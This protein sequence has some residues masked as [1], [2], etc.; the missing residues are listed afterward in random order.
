MKQLRQL[1]DIFLKLVVLSPLCVAAA[2]ADE[3]TPVE[4]YYRC[5]AHMTQSRP[6]YSDPI[7]ARIKAKE[8]DPIDACL[9]IF[10]K[11]LF[12]QAGG[13][14]IAN[15][16]DDTAQKVVATF[17]RLHGS[18]V[19][20]K[21]LG[22]SGNAVESAGLRSYYN[23]DDSSLYFTRAMFN[24]SVPVSSIV[25][26]NAHLR[27]IRTND[28]PAVG[29][30]SPN[31]V[32]S[33]FM[34][35][36]NTLFTPSGPLVGVRTTDAMQLPY[37]YPNNQRQITTGSVQLGRH[38]GGGILGNSVYLLNTINEERDFRSNNGTQMPR[39]WSR[40]VFNDLL[41]RELP[42]VRLE[43]A[44]PFVVPTSNV[45]F[46]QSANCTNC[47]ASID[48]MSFLIKGFRY[49]NHAGITPAPENMP[50]NGGNFV[51]FYPV[52]RPHV[53][54][55]PANTD[56]NFYRRPQQDGR[57]Y[58]RNFNGSLVDVEVDTMS[59]LGA[60]MAQQDDFYACL[61]KRYYK[62]FSGIAVDLGDP[63]DPSAVVLNSLEQ[64]H[65]SKVIVW[66]AALKT[67]Q[68]L[69]STIREIISHADYK[70]RDFGSSEE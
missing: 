10:N 13:E 41:C 69:R 63:G 12:T 24:P 4:L 1:T 17:A 47:H 39:K 44:A 70:K 16:V 7:I 9:G 3:L 18:W 58:F 25:T 38:L 6:A 30:L 66:A 45:E 56:E 37:T 8:V 61:V 33:R 46:R 55:W 49:E 34:F 65:R 15:P 29:P 59:E 23:P 26:T 21:N 62:Y 35:G 31:D 22:A 19:S 27:S 20:D 32:K 2:S 67:S 53:S 51:N 42:V 50:I 5:Y 68:D 52:E 57:L 48:R 54:G 64:R 36:L 28:N 14:S 11:G 40:A 43:D 60:A